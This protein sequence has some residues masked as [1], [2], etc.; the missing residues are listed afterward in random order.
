MR[1]EDYFSGKT[2]YVNLF[3]Q[4]RKTYH[5]YGKLT[6][7]FK[8]DDLNQTEKKQLALF[9]SLPDF[10]LNEKKRIRWSLFEK[11]Y[12]ASRFGDRPLIEVMGRVLR[13]PFTTK[14]E[15]EARKASREENFIKLIEN[16]MPTLRFLLDMGAGKPLYDWY[17]ENKNEAILGLKAIQTALTR[18]PEKLTRLPYFSYQVTGNPHTFDVG[19]RIGKM[20]IH[21]L[22]MKRQSDHSAEALS[23]TEFYS[24]VLMSFHLVRDDVMN[25]T[26]V[27]GLLAKSGGVEHPMWR[28]SVDTHVSW[29]VPVRHLL[30]VDEVHPARGKD[31]YL[32]E[33]SGVYSTFLDARPELALVCTNGQFRLATWLLLEKLAESGCR[34]HYSGDFDPEG[35][36]MADQI[37]QRFPG[38]VELWDM[39]FEHY[40]LSNPA[41]PISGQRLQKL[42]LIKSPE[43]SRLAGQ[44]QSIKRAG[45]QEAISQM[46]LGKVDD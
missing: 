42:K 33:N 37:L 19:G 1:A 46:L 35:L 18:L 8:L 15:D 20:F 39:D 16:E 22:Q 38:Q 26:T 36:L 17:T 44:M 30:E 5:Q 3:S 27:N 31:V 24:D 2:L 40:L 25:F 14:S 45:Y 11:A 41:I 28:A 7:T 4:A 43:L 32:V 10:Q 29:N 34:L 21:V 6:G 13:R 9:L 12:A 23:R